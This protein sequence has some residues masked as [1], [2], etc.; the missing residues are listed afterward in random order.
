MKDN[1]NARRVQKRCNELLGEGEGKRLCPEQ[2]DR[3]LLVHVSTP[4]STITYLVN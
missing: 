2:S 4:L 3:G 1:A